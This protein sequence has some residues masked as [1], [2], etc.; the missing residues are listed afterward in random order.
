MSVCK[1]CNGFNTGI[2][3][4]CVACLTAAYQIERKAESV[5]HKTDVTQPT[6]DVTHNKP[7]TR[8]TSGDVIQ[9]NTPGMCK[10]CTDNKA[11]WSHSYCRACEALRVKEWRTARHTI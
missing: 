4:Y 6:P 8:V 5:T 3:D 10:L 9:C 7:V 11:P 1:G 2:G